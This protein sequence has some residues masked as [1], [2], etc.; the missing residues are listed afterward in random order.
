MK[1]LD[2][3]ISDATA[4]A[5]VLK[6]SLCNQL[7]GLVAINITRGYMLFDFFVRRIRQN[8]ATPRTITPPFKISEK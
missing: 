3:Y 1:A 6:D 4:Y 7:T 2:G 5:L 8:Q